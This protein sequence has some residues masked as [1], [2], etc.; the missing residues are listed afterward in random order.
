MK[1]TIVQIT[2]THIVERG[3]KLLGHIDTAAFLRAAVN[4]IEQL[5]PAPA[6]ILATGDMTNDGTP[7]QYEHLAELLA[8][9]AGRLVMVPGNHDRV[10]AMWD[11]LPADLIAPPDIRWRPGGA[12][13]VLDRGIRSSRLDTSRPH[14]TGVGWRPSSWSGWITSWPNNQP[15]APSWCCITHR[16]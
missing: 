5:A 15:S 16:S 10:D 3:Q 13:A 11:S 6:L 4:Q 8:P 7:E 1:S 2:D 9:F 12:D 14:T